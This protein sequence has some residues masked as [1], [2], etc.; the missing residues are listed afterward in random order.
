[1]KTF[2]QKTLEEKVQFL[3]ELLGA[4]LVDFNISTEE[5]VRTIFNDEEKSLNFK[6]FLED[7]C[8]SM[9]SEMRHMSDDVKQQADR[10]YKRIYEDSEGLEPNYRD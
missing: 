3:A 7:I 5:D 1:M 8:D 6:P 4:I 2:K 9:S 10:I